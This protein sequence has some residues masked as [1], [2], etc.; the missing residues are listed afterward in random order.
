[1]TLTSLERTPDA[2]IVIT[3]RNRRELLRGAV[4]SALAQSA[5][6][7]VIVVDDAST[8]GTAE[9]IISEFPTVRLQRNER[10]T[11]PAAERNTGVALA[12]AECVVT[13]DDDAYFS[14]PAVIE[15]I[16]RD[17]DHPRV[18]AVAI[19]YINARTEGFVRQRAPS[20]EGVYL[21]PVSG[22]GVMA[23]RRAVF[24]ALGGYRTSFVEQNEATDLALRLL[25][26][27]F[28]T[29][30]GRSDPIVHLEARDGSG[31]DARYFYL[32]RNQ[33]LFAWAN[34]PA[35]YHLERLVV[36]TVKTQLVGVRDRHARSTLR[37]VLDGCRVLLRSPPRR[38]P[39]SR[40]AYRISRRLRARSPLTLQDIEDRLPPP[41]IPA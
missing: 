7:E 5:D 35:P 15:Q 40:A 31:L 18:G 27:G 22:E 24:L 10:A 36:A 26:R 29:R 1:M 12:L 32:G 28:V 20:D 2:S 8:D 41:T 13:L 3:T 37:G 30:L 23:V 25:D 17:L 33:S 16:I 38:E 21:A 4:E 14:T 39:V 34:V 11:G 6:V 19:P 9:L